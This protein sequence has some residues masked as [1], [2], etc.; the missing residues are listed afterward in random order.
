MLALDIAE[1]EVC[2]AT[3]LNNFCAYCMQLHIG[4]WRIKQTPFKE[5]VWNKIEYHSPVFLKKDVV[6]K[7][8]VAMSEYL[9]M[10]PLGYFEHL[11]VKN[12][13]SSSERM[14]GKKNVQGNQKIRIKNFQNFQKIP[15]SHKC[16]SRFRYFIIFFHDVELSK[17]LE[18]SEEDAVLF[19]PTR[20]AA[21]GLAVGH[22]GSTGPNGNP[23]PTPD[24]FS[25]SR[26]LHPARGHTP[27]WVGGIKEVHYTAKVLSHSLLFSL[28]LPECFWREL[29]SY[30]LLS[31]AFCYI[32]PPS[33]PYAQNVTPLFNPVFI[34]L[35]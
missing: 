7:F 29:T 11:E 33:S 10:T 19:A 28:A 25:C 3:K 12:V 26:V 20:D 34:C 13:G 35:G 22:G 18:D 4:F 17:Q 8:I 1:V 21:C 9:V 2:N 6:Y 14:D 16:S 30:L 31:A 5:L 32:P 27:E 15:A 23:A 24:L